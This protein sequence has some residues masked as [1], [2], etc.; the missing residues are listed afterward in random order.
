M[1][2]LCEVN[3]IQTTYHY[4]QYLLRAKS[5]YYLHSPFVY[6]LAVEVIFDKRE[7]YAFSDINYVKSQLLQ[8]HNYIDVKD[9]GAGSKG[10]NSTARRQIS[11]IAK[12]AA[13]PEKVGKLLFRL[14][15]YFQPKT[16]LELGTSLGIGTL[17]HALALP[18]SK[19]YTIEG[20]PNTAQIARK[21][22]DL[23]ELPNIYTKVGTFDE[24]LPTT[25]AEI[26]SLDYVFFDGNHRKEPTLQYFKRC[27]PYIHKDTIMVFDDINWSAE[28]QEAWSKIKAHP[29]VTITIDL[30][31]LG[32]VFFREE[33]QNKEHFQLYF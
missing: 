29:K 9:H 6:Q 31:R 19:V 21:T 32:I 28:M 26:G 17:Y 22:F 27:L 24:K 30:F 14:V 5:K 16:M 11:E 13:T 1:F 3:K 23:M 7:Y 12:N 10:S 33:Q 20:C 4:L 2:Y 25:L 8:N 15:S 18:K